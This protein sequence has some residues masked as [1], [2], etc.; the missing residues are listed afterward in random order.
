MKFL[1]VTVLLSLYN[2]NYG[3]FF[4]NEKMPN[5][6]VQLFQLFRHAWKNTCYKYIYIKQDNRLEI[7]L[8]SVKQYI[9][10]NWTKYYEYNILFST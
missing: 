5:K 10:W 8:K 6:F 2:M 4:E 3:C 7:L 9:L 1:Y